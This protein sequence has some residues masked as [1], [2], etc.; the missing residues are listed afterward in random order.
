MVGLQM[1]VGV[2]ASALVRRNMEGG[3]SV[4]MFGTLTSCLLTFIV[5]SIHQG[6]ACGLRQW[7]YFQD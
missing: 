5:A 2:K 6:E 7:S 4:G 3:A 1:R